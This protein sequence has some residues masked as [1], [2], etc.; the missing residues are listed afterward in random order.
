[1]KYNL[2]YMH[3]LSS[4]IYHFRKI[5]NGLYEREDGVVIGRNT[6]AG[7]YEFITYVRI[8]RNFKYITTPNGFRVMVRKYFNEE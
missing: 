3:V 7:A 2:Q 6:M 5:R 1:M 8:A 4:K